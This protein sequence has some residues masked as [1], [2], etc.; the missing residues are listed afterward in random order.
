MFLI[1]ID[2]EIE[3]MNNSSIEKIFEYSGEEAF[4]EKWKRMRSSVLPVCRAG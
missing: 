1:D 2:S 3:E 4:F